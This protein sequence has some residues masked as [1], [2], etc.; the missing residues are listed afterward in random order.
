MSG[1]WAGT[2]LTRNEGG[3]ALAATLA[4]T[5]FWASVT[6]GRLLFAVIQKRVPSR[7]VYRVIPL[8]VAAASLAIAIVARGSAVLAVLEF[9]LAGLGCS[10]LLPLTISFS[11]ERFRAASVSGII[12]AFYQVGYGVSA[13]GVGPLIGGGVS[14]ATVF[15]GAG[16]VALVVAGLAFAATR[17]RSSLPLHGQAR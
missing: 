5:A 12:I 2:F 11:E 9:A 17:H 1:N 7:W 13:F 14:L 16:V 4:L 10:A 8:L 15:A 3:G 6:V